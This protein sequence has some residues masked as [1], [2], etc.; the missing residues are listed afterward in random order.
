MT[1]LEIKKGVRLVNKDDGTLHTIDEML[2]YT[3]D[4]DGNERRTWAVFADAD[5]LGRRYSEEEIRDK[6]DILR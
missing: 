1:I 5:N 3:T 6:F 2:Y 4:A